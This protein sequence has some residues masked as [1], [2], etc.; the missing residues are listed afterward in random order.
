MNWFQRL[1]N[2]SAPPAPVQA[3][4]AEAAAPAE[5]GPREKRDFDLKSQEAQRL[6]VYGSPNVSGVAVNNESSLSLPPMFAAMRYI[7]E[8]IAM[9]D[10]VVKQR[11][12]EGV[13]RAP[14]HP[15]QIFMNG[16]P[17]A[18]YTWS[19]LIRAWV[20]NAILGNGYI[21]VHRD[22]WTMRP[23]A[24]ELIPQGN[25]WLEQDPRGALWLRISGELNGRQVSKIVPYS[26]VLHLKG[27]TMNGVNGKQM[28]LV[29]QNTIGAGLAKTQYG[30]SLFGN[31]CYPSIAVKYDEPL[32]REERKTVT[33]NLQDDIGGSRQA[34]T[35]LVLDDGMNVQYL[36][37]SPID[38]ALVDFAKMNAEEVASITK[39]PFEM[40]TPQKFGTRASAAQH[41]Q[42]FLTH[43]L[44]PWLEGIQEEWSTKLFY[45]SEQGEYFFEFDSS[46]YMATDKKTEAETLSI[47]VEGKLLTPNEGRERLGLPPKPGGDD[48]YGDI[49]TLPLE[50]LVEVAIAKYL[51]AEGEKLRGNN[52][53]DTKNEPEPA[54]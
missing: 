7:S 19:D 11:R 33:K 46:M 2:L 24:L 21:V 44:N 53:T 16:R 3:T 43:C 42:N 52:Q 39:V 47:L 22:E 50:N 13:Y 32:D 1:F 49:N 5:A 10:R 34:G 54:Q 29:H 38:V 30:A 35:P 9:L 12:P 40:I 41:N 36:Q 14:E 25:A 26:D 20:N 4:A 51:S 37:W 23:W 27:F 28:A 15:L 6:L 45:T 17:H 8:G 18:N 48:L 31:G